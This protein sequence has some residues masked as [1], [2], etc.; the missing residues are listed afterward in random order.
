M[1]SRSSLGLAIAGIM[2]G[3]CQSNSYQ[4]TGFAREFQDGDTIC[5]VADGPE[6]PILAQTIVESGKFLFSGETDTV[7]L[8]CAYMKQEPDCRVEFFLA[9]GHI[10]IEMQRLPTPSRV[11]G[12]V[13]NNEWQL[14]AD[15]IELLEEYVVKILRTKPS[16]SATQQR[17]AHAIDSLHRRMSD[18]IKNTAHRNRYNALG[19]YIK[20]NY[21]EPEFK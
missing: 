5:I 3:S 16:D 13:F 12:T 9:P 6:A 4:I 11:S 17:N 15:S 18:C 10:T 14:L 19:K 2:L 20:H 8:C 1:H 7:S 21:K